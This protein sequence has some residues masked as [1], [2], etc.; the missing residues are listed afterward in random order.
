MKYHVN[1]ESGRVGKCA[2]TV[3]S[4]KFA[5]DGQMPKHFDNKEQAKKAIEKALTKEFGTTSALSKT[6][7][8][9]SQT[10]QPPEGWDSNDY[11]DEG[12]DREGYDVDGFDK[13]GYSREGYDQ[14]GFDRD[15]FDEDGFSSKGDFAEE[16]EYSANH[17]YREK[18]GDYKERNSGVVVPPKPQHKPTVHEDKENIPPKPNYKPTVHKD[19]VQVPPKPDYGPTVHK[20]DINIPP[21]PRH[22]PTI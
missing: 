10:I 3:Q 17:E 5:V 15:G 11:D 20:E 21:K 13:D 12:F 6:P 16:P 4:C 8:V 1:P 2:A 14:N 9:S 19:N 18:Y 7:A 22:K